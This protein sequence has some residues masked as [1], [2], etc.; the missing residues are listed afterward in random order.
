MGREL[1]EKHLVDLLDGWTSGGA[2]SSTTWHPPWH[3]TWHPTWHSPS[4]LIQLGDDGIAHLFQLLLLV[5][6]LV[7]F[8]GLEDN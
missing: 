7:L 6:I 4:T 3:P 8:S 2:A 5:F 1:L